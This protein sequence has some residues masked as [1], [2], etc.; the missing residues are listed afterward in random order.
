MAVPEQLYQPNWN[1]LRCEGIDPS[2]G[3][4]KDT[5]LRSY[6]SGKTAQTLELD[7]WH[8]EKGFTS[9]ASK[10]VQTF[11]TLGPDYPDNRI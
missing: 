10:C 5:F 11:I 8:R 2:V 4:Y 7:L 9:F 1:S 6:D 3:R